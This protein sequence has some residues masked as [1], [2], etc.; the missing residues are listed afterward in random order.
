MTFLLQVKDHKLHPDA[1][2]DLGN[3]PPLPLFDPKK[4]ALFQK[5]TGNRHPLL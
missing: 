4:V 5:K 3:G 1:L 2:L